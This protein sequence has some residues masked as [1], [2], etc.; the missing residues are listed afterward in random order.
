MKVD[1]EWQKG[2]WVKG[3]ET[4]SVNMTFVEDTVNVL[5]LL[6]AIIGN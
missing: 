6:E 4:M 2:S 1:T 5:N 3:T